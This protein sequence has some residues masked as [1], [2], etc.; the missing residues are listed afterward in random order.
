MGLLRYIFIDRRVIL[1]YVKRDA[2]HF[3]LYLRDS[4]TLEKSHCLLLSLFAICL[5]WISQSYRF[6]RDP[7]PSRDA[8]LDLWPSVWIWGGGMAVSG[9]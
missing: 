2:G 4:K 9:F 5:P 7:R 3:G 6:L 8:E 1:D